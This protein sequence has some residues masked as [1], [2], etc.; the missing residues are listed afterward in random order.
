[1]FLTRLVSDVWEEIARAGLKAYQDYD[2]SC[3]ESDSIQEVIDNKERFLSLQKKN[4]A[5]GDEYVRLFDGLIDQIKGL[6]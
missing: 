6:A 4:R 3:F 5:L 2:L 1:M